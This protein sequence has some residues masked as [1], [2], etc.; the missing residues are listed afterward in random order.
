MTSTPQLQATESR[1]RAALLAAL[2]GDGEAYRAFLD[3]LSGHLR[4]FV[5]RRLL[6]AQAD[7]ED[8]VQETLLAI[9]N[10]RHT[11]RPEQ[12]LTA[13]VHAIARYKLTDFLRTHAR[14]DAFTDPLDDAL[15]ILA[16]SDAQQTEARLDIGKLLA[17]LPEKQRLP[18]LHVKLQGLSIQ[19]TAALTGLSEAAVKVGIHRGLKALAA[20]IQETT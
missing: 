5:R 18:I 6:H 19:E 12:P 14:H 10:S 9:H 20:R 1:L 17:L 15:G 7:V 13:W 3:E 8:I 4:A 2:Q 16:A 11:Y